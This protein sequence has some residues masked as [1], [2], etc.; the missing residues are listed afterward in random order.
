MSKKNKKIR[1]VLKNNEN[2]GAVTYIKKKQDRDMIKSQ[3]Q[4][5]RGY[6]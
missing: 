2:I 6:L 4:R 5:T 3:K 1:I